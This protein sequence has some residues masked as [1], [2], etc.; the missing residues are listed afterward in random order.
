MY[1]F[2]QYFCLTVHL[3]ETM[4][5]SSILLFL[6]LFLG[7]YPYAL[8]AQYW[9]QKASYEI[10]VSLD[11]LNHELTGN[12]TLTYTNNS[13]SSMDSL[14]F[15]FW[16]NAY[17]SKN[18][19]FAKQQIRNGSLAF[20]FAREEDMGKMWGLDISVDESKVDLKYMVASKEIGGI[21]LPSPLAPGKTATVQT[22][23]KVKL[24]SVF[25]RMGH[26][27]Q[28]YSITQ[29]FPKV[30][31]YDAK[32]WHFFPY[33]DLGEFYDDF[34][35]YDVHITVPKNYVVAATG[36]LLTKRENQWLAERAKES[37]KAM[38]KKDYSFMN[39]SGDSMKTL[40]FHEDNIHDF[41]WFANSRFLV[42][43]N[44]VALDS[45]H[46]V[47]TYTFFTEDHVDDWSR[48][49]DYVGQS[50]SY[51]S[52]TVGFYPY[53]TV[54][55]VE[56]P[57]VA[58]GG[59]EYP[60]ITVVSQGGDELK[61]VILHE[62]GHNWFQGMFGTNERRFPYL[63]E[64]FNSYYENRYYRER[65]D[66]P[67][68]AFE[69]LFTRYGLHHVVRRKE[70]QSIN[71]HS[72]HYSSINY[73]LVVYGKAAE[74]LEFLEN[75]LG[76]ELMDSCMHTFYKEWYLKHP[77]PEDFKEVFERV[78]EKNLNWFFDG[79]MGRE[80]TYDYGFSKGDDNTVNIQNL[81]DITAPFK[82]TFKDDEGTIIEEQWISGLKEDTSV[83]INSSATEVLINDEVGY[84][85]AYF[86]NNYYFPNKNGK[87]YR[88]LRFGAFN[89][90]EAPGIKSAAFIPVGGYNSTDGGMA[91]L[92]IYTPI[93]PQR[94][95]QYQLVPMLGFDS[96]NFLWLANVQRN[97]YWRRGERLK[98]LNIGMS[99][100]SFSIG[101]FDADGAYT[102]HY[103]KFQPFFN[104]HFKDKTKHRSFQQVHGRLV[105]RNFHGDSPDWRAFGEFGY[106]FMK[107][108][109]TFPFTFNATVRGGDAFVSASAELS[110][111][112]PYAAG[113][114]INF[115]FFGGQL[116]GLSS[117]GINPL[118][119]FR[120]NNRSGLF[121]YMLDDLVFDR[122]L[123]NDFFSRQLIASEGGIT[124]PYSHGSGSYMMAANVA[125]ELPKTP[126]RAM[127]NAVVSPRNNPSANEGNVL[128]TYEAGLQ[129]QLIRS[130]L[131]VNMP[132]IYSADL[133][134]HNSLN[135]R[136][137]TDNI[138]FTL[139]LSPLNPYGYKEA[140]ILRG[141]L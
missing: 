2:L 83:A 60:T 19:A 135:T 125:A 15:H 16:P 54:K 21:R 70:D 68:S 41:A 87:H 95:L 141:N 52:E 35:S 17:S 140:P 67:L 129:L 38:F 134:N 114:D 69:Q 123:Q 66:E 32:G 89:P 47:A 72:D 23:F 128:L 7:L 37:K 81:G 115:R 133:Q 73:G 25:S 11:T 107:T 28:H 119:N 14:Y 46:N 30:A 93:F 116:I 137:F 88:R 102:H 91:G 31:K 80:N 34:G 13:P 85:E 82:L 127:L 24:P 63:D 100:Q 36:N 132:F 26:E 74:A 9:Q 120:V 49:I 106:R 5:N 75:Y 105:Y 84:I 111:T 12:I 3:S 43:I 29:W 8:K 44:E 22:P 108:D 10:E 103:K 62:V 40:H 45:V 121:D 20:R 78:S 58:G 76:K 51:Y 86:Q 96:G 99:S 130:V 122:A 64:G 6:G 92:A 139:K 118:Y 110:G 90:V 117:D 57:L 131:Y 27:E 39:G 42:S 79:F 59:M 53:K 98:Q 113:K 61:R 1:L 65:P 112:L 104:Y 94:K 124:T 109:P 33:L 55:A 126:L 18:S 48:A 56:G 97:W 101:G 138:T 71:L 77:G 136:S 50:V 4:R